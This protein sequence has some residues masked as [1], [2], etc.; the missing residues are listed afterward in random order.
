[1]VVF[2]RLLGHMGC[3]GVM[4]IGEVGQREGHG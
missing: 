4:G 3:K 2:Q 1:V